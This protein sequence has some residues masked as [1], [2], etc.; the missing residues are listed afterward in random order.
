MIDIHNHILPLVDDGSRSVEMSLE[1]LE[2]AYRDGTDEMILTPHLAYAYGFDNPHDKIQDLFHD[3]KRIVNDAGIPIRMHLGCEFLYSSKRTFENHFEEITK[4]A[5]TSYL[6]MEFYFDVEADEILEAVKNVLDKGCYPVIAHPERF[7]AIQTDLDVAREVIRLGGYLQMNKGS[8]LGDYGP[9]AKE[10]VLALLDE[11][12][13][14]FVGSDA[15]NM[16]SRY[17][18]MYES[19]RTVRHYFGDDMARKIF[20]ENPYQLLNG[21]KI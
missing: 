4:L 15:H 14:H 11:G 6:L 7:E 1:M 18:S 13:I 19:F 3:F 12:L 2:Q 21:G 17:P 10:T 8:I 9:F 5:G 16:H 20:E